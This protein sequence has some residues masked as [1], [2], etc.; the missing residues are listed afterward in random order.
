MIA[1]TLDPS[2]HHQ[3]LR[4]TGTGH[5]LISS[6]QV[7]RAMDGEHERLLAQH[8]LRLLKLFL[9]LGRCRFHHIHHPPILPNAPLTNHLQAGTTQMQHL[10]SPAYSL[11]M[12]STA[13][14]VQAMGFPE[15]A[16][17]KHSL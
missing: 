5:H 1:H 14:I 11:A 2:S 12:R 7:R 17:P 13:L 15:S 6:R 8:P 3:A 9:F 10:P 4:V 16:N